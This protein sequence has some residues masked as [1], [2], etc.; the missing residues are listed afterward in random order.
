MTLLGLAA[1]VVYN[2]VYTPLKRVTPFAALPGSF[3]GAL[4]PADPNCCD[5]IRLTDSI[6]AARGVMRPSRRWNVAL[7]GPPRGLSPQ[8]S[9]WQ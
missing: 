6:A 1:A 5:N 4:P 8:T 9:D 2:G 7:G 3:I